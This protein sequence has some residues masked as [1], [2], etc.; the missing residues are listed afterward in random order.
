MMSDLNTSNML[1]ESV[2]RKKALSDETIILP[3]HEAKA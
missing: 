3:I 1:S 2:P